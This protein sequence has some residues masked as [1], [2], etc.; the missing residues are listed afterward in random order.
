MEQNISNLFFL[1]KLQ[2]KVAWHSC[3]LMNGKLVQKRDRKLPFSNCR[4]S[5]LITPNKIA[6]IKFIL[7]SL[8]N[9]K[10]EFPSMVPTKWVFKQAA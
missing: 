6:K 7:N 10:K 8:T 9:E 3:Y 4:N 5:K 2:K 1:K